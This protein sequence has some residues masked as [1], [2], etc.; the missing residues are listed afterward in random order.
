[1]MRAK[2]GLGAAALVFLLGACGGGGDDKE[3]VVTD[4]V[5]RCSSIGTQPFVANGTACVP[6]SATPVLLLLVVDADG[7]VGSCSGVKVAPG[8]VLTAA[9]CVD[10]SSRAV[11]GVLWDAQGKATQ[12]RAQSWVGHPAFSETPQYFVN[13]VAIVSFTDA[14][15]SPAVPLLLSQSSSKGQAILFS[16]WGAPDYVLSVGSARIDEVRDDYLRIS[17][18]GSLSNACPGDSGGPATRMVSGRQVVVGLVSAGTAGCNPGGKTF[19]SNLAK[20]QVSEFI[21]AQV[22]GAEIL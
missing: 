8:R 17:Y 12:V 22:P 13:D 10:P 5:Q 19:F 3:V 2:L 21:R 7:E 11:F 16:G 9:H 14:L 1:M 15:P 6:S 20:S 18:D 4:P